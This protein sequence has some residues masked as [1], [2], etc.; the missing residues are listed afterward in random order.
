MYE[1]KGF[2]INPD[3]LQMLCC[4]ET[5]LPLQEAD[6]LLLKDLNQKISEKALK[7]LSGQILTTPLEGVLV[8]TDGTRAYPVIEDIPV[9]LADEAIILKK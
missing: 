9:L 5:K 1:K 7:N 3:L 8:T 4:P 6:D 2:M